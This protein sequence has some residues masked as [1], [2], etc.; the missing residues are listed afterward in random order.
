MKNIK[1]KVAGMH[2]AS[3]AA[4]ITKK[5]SKLWGIEKVDVNFATEEA[6]INFDPEKVSIKKMNEELQKFGYSFSDDNSNHDKNM[7]DHSMNEDHSAHAGIGQ[8]KERKVKELK[9]FKRKMQFATPIAL[10]VF[11]VMIYD[12]LVET[13]S[14]GELPIPKEVMNAI[15]L[16]LATAV[17]FWAGQSFLIGVVRFIRYRAANMDTLIGLGTLAAYVYSL[18][19]TLFPPIREAFNLPEFT[20]FDVTI[21]VIGFVILG[22]YLEARSKIRTGEAIEKLLNLQSKTALLF[23]DGKVSCRQKKF[24]RQLLTQ[25]CLELSCLAFGREYSVLPLGRGSKID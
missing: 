14:F 17:L 24:R 9:A 3:C 15:L 18:I 20:Y 21:V 16:I 11:I 12:I 10:M 5:V 8:S 2:C 25:E 1:T 6:R 22:K 23:R 4:I 19:I 7:S 13:F